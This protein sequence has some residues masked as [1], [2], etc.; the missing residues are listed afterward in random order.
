MSIGY[1]KGTAGTPKEGMYGTLESGDYVPDAVL[2][3]KA[4]YDAYV[5]T[6]PALVPSKIKLK[7]IST[8]ITKEYEVIQ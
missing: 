6:F 3:T 5:A 2:C 7:E 1:W 4:E 8:G